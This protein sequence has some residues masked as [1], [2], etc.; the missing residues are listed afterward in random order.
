MKDMIDRVNFETLQDHGRSKTINA[1]PLSS[2]WIGGL[3]FASVIVLV[4]LYITGVFS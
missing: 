4:V 2:N 3:A 1:F